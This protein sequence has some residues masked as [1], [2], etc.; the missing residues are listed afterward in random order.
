MVLLVLAAVQLAWPTA[1]LPAPASPG[2][3]AQRVQ[4]PQIG[5]A[6]WTAIAERPLFSP[7][8]RPNPTEASGPSSL[9]GLTVLGIAVAD[10]TAS[11]VVRLPSGRVARLQPGQ[12][13]EDWVMASIEPLR[14]LFE[15]N[16]ATRAFPFEAKKLR[17]PSE[18]SAKRAKP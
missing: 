5:T 2:Q 8:R 3:P 16:G 9:D 1:E 10:R 15:K 14:L 17:P 13:L 11:A 4:E 12:R 7:N 6:E 18:R